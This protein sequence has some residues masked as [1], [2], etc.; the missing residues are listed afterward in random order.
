MKKP[1][2]NEVFTDNGEH[3]HWNLIDSET[4]IN[5][6]SEDAREDKAQGFPVND[7]NNDTG[8]MQSNTHNI[9]DLLPTDM[10]IANAAL[11]YVDEETNHYAREAKRK[12]YIAGAKDMRDKNIYIS[13]MR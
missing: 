8:D 9:K 4:G 13:N 12:S 3:S 10:D 7:K 2:V 1:I 5:I 11:D 6:W